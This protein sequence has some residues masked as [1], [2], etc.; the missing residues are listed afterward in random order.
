MGREISASLRVTSDWVS[1]TAIAA[2][3][4]LP[5][6]EVHNKGERISPRSGSHYYSKSIVKLT[7]RLAADASV[8]EHIDS[9]MSQF[10][11]RP[12]RSREIQEKCSVELWVKISFEPSQ[13]GFDLRPEIMKR[14][15]DSGIELIFDIYCS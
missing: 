8:S 12:H 4:A 5:C 1:G 11:S 15:A 9:L 2:D 10:E 7:S 13:L 6:L 14:I 3:L